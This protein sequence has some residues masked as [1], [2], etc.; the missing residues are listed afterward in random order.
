M[1]VC[2]PL[3]FR[4][5]AFEH[6]AMLYTEDN[7]TVANEPCPACKSTDTLYSYRSDVR[8]IR[9]AEVWGSK[10]APSTERFSCNTCGH[11]WLVEM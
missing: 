11:K 10:D 5:A 6:H 3:C 8:D 1:L 9:K 7:M 4:S 2:C